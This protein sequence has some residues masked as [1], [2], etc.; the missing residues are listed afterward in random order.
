MTG[1]PRPPQII[2]LDVR[3]GRLLI[4]DER[5]AF[6]E[7]QAAPVRDET[8]ISR[9]RVDLGARVL[10]IVLP[11]GY[12]ATIALQIGAIAQRAFLADHP[13]V[14]LDQN[15]WSKVAGAIHGWPRIGQLDAAAATILAT[16]AQQG[17]IVMPLSAGHGVETG[18][19]DRDKR[20]QLASTMVEL[21]QGWLMRS[22]LWIRGDELASA[23]DGHPGRAAGV[24]TQDADQWFSTRLKDPHVSDLPEP[25]RSMAKP[26]INML[27]I[28]STLLERERMP[29]RGGRDAAERWAR[30]WQQ[31]VDH[32]R[33]DHL[34]PQRVRQV[35]NAQ[36][37]V[38]AGRELSYVWQ[39]AQPGRMDAWIARSYE[40]ITLL[41]GM[42]RLRAIFF[43]RIRNGDVW[44]GNDLNDMMYLC[45]A[46][47]Y[48]DLVVGERHIIGG[49][50][51]DH[52][53]H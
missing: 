22:P 18:R 7:V 46:A 32:V 26:V 21:S 36:V 35:A 39:D 17:R 33:A 9:I 2:E 13:V 8:E 25:A 42:S 34:P 45:T 30:N 41:P 27:S 38:D 37:L 24:F 4:G 19:L 40:D 16:L 6:A 20:S 1:Q 51:N 44:K 29:E 52:P 49:L 3:T 47:G 50:A 43:G 14:Y 48:A 12:V 11:G 28:A 53:D 23:R 31:A 10:T 5:R 15:H